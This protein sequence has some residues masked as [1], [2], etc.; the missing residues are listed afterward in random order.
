VQAVADKAK[1]A[2]RDAG[3]DCRTADQYRADALTTICAAVLTG[4][5]AAL[6]AAGLPMWQGRRPNIDLVIALSTL[7]GADDQAADLTGYG[8]IPATLARLIASDPTATWRRLVTDEQGRLIDYGQTRYRPI[9]RLALE[10]TAQRINPMDHP[11]RTHLREAG[12]RI[13]RRQDETQDRPA[14]RPAVLS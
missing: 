14:R 5:I 12:Q 3:T 6:A 9:R 7:I 13:P 4:D 10:T 8:P 1:A 11:H 2:N